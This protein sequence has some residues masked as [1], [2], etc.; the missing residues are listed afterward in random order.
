MR[1]RLAAA[2]ETANDDIG[3]V[4]EYCGVSVGKSCGVS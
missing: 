2:T 4:K 1:M 3:A